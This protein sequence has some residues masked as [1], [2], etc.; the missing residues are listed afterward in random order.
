MGRLVAVPDYLLEKI[1]AELDKVMP[2]E[3]TDED[4][5]ALRS[6][7]LAFVDKYGKIPEFTVERHQPTEGED[8]DGE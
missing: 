1:D 7:L 5:A 3:A 8:G 2:D 4:R 6:Q